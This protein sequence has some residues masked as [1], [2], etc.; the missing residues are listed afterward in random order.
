MPAPDPLSLY[1]EEFEDSST[2]IIAEVWYYG[3]RRNRLA[4]MS[5]VAK[6]IRETGWICP[7]CKGSVPLYRR[8]DAR[9]CSQGCRKKFARLHRKTRS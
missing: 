6:N 5:A 1:I 8:A 4:R 3:N 7:A 2:S 9:F